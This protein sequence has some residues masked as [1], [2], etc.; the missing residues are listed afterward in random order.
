MPSGSQLV[1]TTATIGMPSRR[2]SDTAM[3]SRFTSTRNIAAGQ[4]AHLL[5]AVERLLV[6]LDVA[7]DARAVL[8]RELVPRRLVRH[9][10][11]LFL[12][13]VERL[14]HGAEVGERAA[15]PAVVD[16]E[17]ARARG[18]HLDRRRG[19]P[20]GSDEEHLA[21]VGGGL[22]QELE[23]F[24]E[25]LERLVEVDDVDAVALAEDE[26]LHLRVPAIGL[27][28]E[29]GAGFDQRRTVSGIGV[30]AAAISLT[31]SPGLRR[32]SG[33]RWVPGVVRPAERSP[34]CGSPSRFC[35]R[36]GR[37]ESGRGP[38]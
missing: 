6:T 13:A 24:L 10:R 7:R 11:E 20:L 27:V 21:A 4:L 1:S 12:E 2:P 30:Y 25:A 34:P 23:R 19:L 32:D 31:I 36:P 14:L 33:L 35:L 3:C 15:Q 38:S 8:L 16:E 22:A 28:A 37:R 29:V 17:L 5:E 26:V 18:F 9:Q